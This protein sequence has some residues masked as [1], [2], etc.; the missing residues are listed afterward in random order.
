[1][2]EG[3]IKEKKEKPFSLMRK[4]KCMRRRTGIIKRTRQITI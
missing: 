3:I 2:L 4:E 1:L